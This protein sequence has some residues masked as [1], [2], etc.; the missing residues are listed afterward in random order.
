MKKRILSLVVAG[1][2]A[3]SLAACGG[4]GTPAATQAASQAAT[5][6]AAE[7]KAEDNKG[8]AD[9]AQIGRAHV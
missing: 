7:S 8:G 3:M 5:Q 9:P 1:A 4:S 6:A 2:M